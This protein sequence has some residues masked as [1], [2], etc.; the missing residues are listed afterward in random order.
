MFKMDLTNVADT[1]RDALPAGKY[2]VV[3]DEAEVK[4][5]KDGM[6]EYINTRFEVMS[7]EYKGRKV[8]TMFNIKNK[9][10]QA[11]DIGLQQLKS[12]LK[13]AG[14]S[15]FVIN[16]VSELVGLK[17]NVALKTKT[18]DFGTKNV[19]SYYSPVEKETT[20]SANQSSLADVP[21]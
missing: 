8:F 4:E 1:G 9:N 13:S 15:N 10:A 5:T 14:R 11:V 3:C 17:A 6:G 16:S 18:D 21:F 2:N 12:F 20:L 19:I 7:G